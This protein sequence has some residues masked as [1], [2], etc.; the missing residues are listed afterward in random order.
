MVSSLLFGLLISSCTPSKKETKNYY[1]VKWLNYDGTVLE[2]DEEVEEG[3]M[4]HYD[5]ME[6]TKPDDAQYEYSFKEWSPK[7]TAVTSNQEYTATFEQDRLKYTIDFDLS[8]GH[9]NSYEG[10]KTVYTFSKDVFFFD[11]VKDGYNFRGWSYK[12]VKVFDEKGIQVSNP[13]TEKNMTFI[14]MFSQTVKL[15]IVTNNANAGLFFGAG[16]YHYNTDVDLSVEVFDGFT[17]AGWYAQDAL[18]STSENYKFRMWSED[19]TLEARFENKYHELTV[20]SNNVTNGKVLLKPN[21]SYQASHLEMRSFTSDV[22]VVALSLNETRFL[23][24]FDEDNKL[25]DTN[26]VYKFTM[27]DDDLTIEAKWNY[28]TVNYELNGGSL[29]EPNPD[30]YTIESTGLILNEPTQPGAE[31]LG[32]VYNDK[33]V[34]E[35]DPTWMKNVTIEAAWADTQYNLSVS[36][37][38]DKGTAS[39]VSGSG[40]AREVIKIKATAAENCV[41]LG[42]YHDD[43]KVSSE[44]EYTFSM[45]ANDYS[46]VAHFQSKTLLGIKPFRSSDKKTVVY[47]LYPQSHLSNTETAIISALN[48]MGYSDKVLNSNYYYYRGYYYATANTTKSVK[49]RDGES[50]AAHT[51]QWF[52]CEPIA[53]TLFNSNVANSG[54]AITSYALE[55]GK[56]HNSLVDT[57]DYCANNYENS[58]M[59]KTLLNNNFYNK[60]FIL[61]S[62]KVQ[63]STVNN[64]AASTGASTNPYACSNTKDY[65]YAPSHQDLT[66]NNFDTNTKRIGYVTD[67][68]IRLGSDWVNSS[69]NDYSAP[70]WT[71]SP[72]NELSSYSLSI[73]NN[74]VFTD[75]AVTTELFLRPACYLTGF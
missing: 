55:I 61:D 63:E 70:Y 18:V 10:P 71:R 40:Y 53:W 42:W 74:G 14:A 19:V 6:P 9:S 27:P 48:S 43:K 51:K 23:G 45:P 5:G 2:T 28:F 21:E 29:A 68:A 72:D 56:Y 37:L 65:V 8:G 44:A 1:E 46:L 52:V 34:T 32:W 36:S 16:E 15:N 11:C 59:R 35:I 7:L 64:S 25:M 58:Y 30:H 22:E 57:V 41:F 13:E 73:S 12:G 54:A 62:A 31:F 24:W 49:F 66:G 39:V 3:A 17:F 38:N 4:P 75:I 26:S 69:N 50:A 67:W 33:I 47:G 20:K 60:A